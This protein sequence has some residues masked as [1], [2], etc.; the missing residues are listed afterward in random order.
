[1]VALGQ[2][3]SHNKSAFALSLDTTACAV[4][5]VL[6]VVKRVV[7]VVLG[8]LTDG[9]LRILELIL[10]AVRAHG[11]VELDV[12]LRVVEVLVHNRPQLVAVL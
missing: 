9:K 7:V 12:V 4:M 6:V 1:M 10:E 2:V 8:V 11:I 5:H 3:V